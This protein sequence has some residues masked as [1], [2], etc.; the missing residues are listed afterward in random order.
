MPL[1]FLLL[2]IL[3]IRSVTLDGAIAG[4]NFLF[5]PDLAHVK[6]TVFLDAMG[7]ASSPSPSAWVV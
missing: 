5:K 7:Q 3:A 4:L 2:I 1:L 6:S